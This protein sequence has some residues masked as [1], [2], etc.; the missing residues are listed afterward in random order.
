M[1][2]PQPPLLLI[3]DSAQAQRPLMEIVE[4]ALESGCRWVSLR[5]KGLPPAHREALLGRLLSLAA[6]YGATAMVHH[7]IRAAAKTGAGGVH[8]GDATRVAEARAVLGRHCLIGVS[9]HAGADMDAAAAAG[10][11]YVTLS[12]ILPSPSKPGYGPALGFAGLERMA[13]RSRLPVL[14]LGGVAAESVGGCLDAGAAGIAVMGE[15]M[16]AAQPAA[17]T[18]RLLRALRRT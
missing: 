4:G 18:L 9:A 11:D 14:A 15:I 12:P 10:A 7:D 16:R 3:T 13:T 17:T 1:R 8:L 6:A 5:E 2:R